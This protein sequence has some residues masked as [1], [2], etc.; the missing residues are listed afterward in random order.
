MNP[1]LIAVLVGAGI[2]AGWYVT[3]WLT[4]F[5]EWLERRR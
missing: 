2:V 5:M 4:R 1:I 3:T